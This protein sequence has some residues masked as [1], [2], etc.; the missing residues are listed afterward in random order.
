M[1]IYDSHSIPDSVGRGTLDP[2]L[3]QWLPHG[4][5]LGADVS[6]AQGRRDHAILGEGPW[7]EIGAVETL[8]L[9]RAA[10][11]AG[12]SAPAFPGDTLSGSENRTG[13]YLE[14]NGICEMVRSLVKNSD[15][16]R[17]PYITPLNASSHA[18]LPPAILV[19]S[20]FDPPRDVGHAYARKL[21]AAGNALAY[22]HNPDLTHGFPAVHALL[23]GMPRGHHATR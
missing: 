5:T 11:L 20:G 8:V 16:G 14:T 6:I 2:E 1:P 3:E 13:L 12:G 9:P 23:A 17:H 19:T 21:A 22:V 15:D 7:P 18:D 10:R 4:P